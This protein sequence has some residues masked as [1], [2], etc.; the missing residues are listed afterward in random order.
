MA[1]KSTPTLAVPGLK[2]LP[3]AAAFVVYEKGTDAYDRLRVNGD[4]E[5]QLDDESTTAATVV[6]VQVGPLI[7]LLVGTGPQA[8]QAIGRLYSPLGLVQALTDLGGGDVLDVTKLY[9]AVSVR[10]PLPAPSAA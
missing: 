9:T 1:T 2:A 3:Q 10:I 4:V 7:D 6:G 8:A 5:L